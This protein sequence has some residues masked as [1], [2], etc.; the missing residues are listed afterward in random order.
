M[1]EFKAHLECFII[2]RKRIDR[3]QILMEFL[4]ICN[5]Y[6]A[7]KLTY[8]NNYL[9]KNKIHLVFV[10]LNSFK[11]PHAYL[12]VCPHYVLILSVLEI[13]SYKQ[14]EYHTRFVSDRYNFRIEAFQ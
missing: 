9:I 13:L 12:Q 10:V 4:A 8:A 2:R 11:Q 14:K 1:R 6:I 7:Y 3:I 5:L